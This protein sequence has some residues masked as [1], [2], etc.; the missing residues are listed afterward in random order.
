MTT[1]SSFSTSSKLQTVVVTGGT[2]G[3]GLETLKQLVGRPNEAYHILIGCRKIPSTEEASELRNAARHEGNGSGHDKTTIEY[4]PLDL[5]SY[6]SVE[7]FAEEV[8]RNISRKQGV[9]NEEEAQIDV[10]FMCAGIVMHQY[11]SVKLPN[12]KEV[13][14]TL[15][16]NVLSHVY[17]S[18][19]LLPNLTKDS[20][21]AIVNSALHLRGAK[22]E[23]KYMVYAS[24]GLLE[25]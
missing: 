21:V 3:L 11:E 7:G 23:L 4:L 2:A 17:L 14:G 5:K 1:P 25:H 24:F 20:R 15:F 12:G 9:A 19:L 8:R 6:A 13:E 16:V 10:L 22:S 18:K